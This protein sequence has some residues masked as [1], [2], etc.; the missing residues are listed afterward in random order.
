MNLPPYLDFPTI[1]GDDIVLRKIEA[2]DII[3]IIEIS[4]YDAIAASDLLEAIAM[5]DKINAD[6][7]NG[8]SIHWGIADKLSNKIVGTC[9]YYRGLDQGRGELSCVLLPHNYGKGYMTKALKLAVQ[10]GLEFIKLDHIGAIT[11][12]DNTSPIKLME[13]L[14]F[15]KIADLCDNEI[16]YQYINSDRIKT[17][18]TD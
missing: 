3:D 18:E 7:A 16:E 11:T 8:D 13:R 4:Y 12:K 10:F 5:Q 2:D 1:I 14:N 15:V 17:S 6:Y 9:G